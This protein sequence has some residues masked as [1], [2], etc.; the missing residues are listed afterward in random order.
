VTVSRGAVPGQ[1]AAL[2][3]VFVLLGLVTDGLYALTA[4]TAA[5]WLRA[6]RGATLTRR[7]IPGAMY[8]GLGLA[9][10]LGSGQRK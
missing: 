1:V 6:R 8:I 2:G 4:G 9:A 3:V 10:A 7:W 5:R